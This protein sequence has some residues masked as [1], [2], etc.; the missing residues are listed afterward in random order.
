MML[1]LKRN[2]LKVEV[3]KVFS[4]IYTTRQGLTLVATHV[5]Y[6]GEDRQKCFAEKKHA[7]SALK[8]TFS[9]YDVESLGYLNKERLT[10]LIA[11]FNKGKIPDEDTVQFILRVA[12]HREGNHN[13]L[14]IHQDELCEAIAISKSYLRNEMQINNIMQK[15]HAQDQDAL[16]KSQIRQL[17][18]DLNGG[19]KVSENDIKLWFS[20]QQEKVKKK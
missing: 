19:R 17:L 20:M 12:G 9:L 16:N 6:A 15:Y 13:E 10:K 14:V 4:G 1:F 7:K 18:S 5:R 2:L 3:E 8:K 11:K